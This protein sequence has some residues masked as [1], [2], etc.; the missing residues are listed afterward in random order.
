MQ[1]LGHAAIRLGHFR[2]LRDHRAFS[3]RLA[4]TP[5]AAPVGLQLLD[6]L[7]N[8]A[9]AFRLAVVLL[10]EFCVRFF[11]DSIV[12]FFLDEDISTRAAGVLRFGRG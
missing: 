8:L 3:I 12:L 7:V 4:R 11:A 1:P 9:G 2:H 6:A 5:S 10:L